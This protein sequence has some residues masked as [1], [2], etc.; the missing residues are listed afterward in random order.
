MPMGKCRDSF[1]RLDRTN[2]VVHPGNRHEPD[3]RTEHRGETLNVY[4]SVGAQ[5]DQIHDKARKRTGYR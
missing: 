1:N 3:I 2:L 5:G 4:L